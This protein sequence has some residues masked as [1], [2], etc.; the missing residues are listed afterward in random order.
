MAPSGIR[1]ASVIYLIRVKDDTLDPIEA[2]VIAERMRK[3]IQSRSD[4]AADVVA[5][6]GES[7]ETLRL[8]GIPYSVGARARGDVQCR[9]QLADRDGLIG[10][11]SGTARSAEHR[12]QMHIQEMSLDSGFAPSVRPRMTEAHATLTSMCRNMA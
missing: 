2:D 8:Y 3:K 12:I 5:V 9:L 4:F 7:K 10:Y 1:N 6:E 11:H